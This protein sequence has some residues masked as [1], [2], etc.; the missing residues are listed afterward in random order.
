MNAM[1]RLLQDDLNRLS[2][3]L[4]SRVAGE[5]AAAVRSLDP[6]LSERLD[7]SSAWLADLRLDLVDRYAMWAR[8][9]EECEALWALAEA[10]VEAE[11][12]SLERRAA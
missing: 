7:R 10:E 6:E 5:T 8:A 9:L 3:R 12:M 4:A 11:R 1:D 2:D